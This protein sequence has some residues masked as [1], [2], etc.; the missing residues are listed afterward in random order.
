M[1]RGVGGALAW[2]LTRA[3]LLAGAA[4]ALSF[5][6][7]AQHAVPQLA[8]LNA[9]AVGGWALVAPGGPWHPTAFIEHKGHVVVEGFLLV[10]ITLLL[11]Q[12][13]FKPGAQEEERLT[14]K[15]RG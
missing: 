1:A 13:S 15:V 9:A 8:K 11:L 6:P 2:A 5:L 10:V 14:E 3:L 12:G 7:A 4:L